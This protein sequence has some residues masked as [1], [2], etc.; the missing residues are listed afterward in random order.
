MK[1]LLAATTLLVSF[2]SMAGIKYICKEQTKNSWDEKKTLVLTQ[3]GNGRINEGRKYQFTLEVYGRNTSRPLLAERVM[4]ETE[5]VMFGFSN[6]AKGI[7]GMI[8]LDELD[9]A[10]L[11][12]GRSE[13]AFDCN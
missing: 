1:M 7:S 5:D 4:V 10:W 9:Q 2:Q 3:V 12:V 11:R 13:V 8:Y 6:Q